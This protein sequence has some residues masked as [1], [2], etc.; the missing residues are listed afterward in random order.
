MI[1]QDMDCTQSNHHSSNTQTGTLKINTFLLGRKNDAKWEPQVLS[2]G[3]SVLN[4]H[5]SFVKFDKKCFNQYFKFVTQ[6]CITYRCVAIV[7]ANSHQESSVSGSG[8]V[9]A[10]NKC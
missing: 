4:R 5:H 7:K 8:S 6:V 1:L 3:L 2:F 9:N 10:L